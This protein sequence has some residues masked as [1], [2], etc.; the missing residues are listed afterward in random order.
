MNEMICKT[1]CEDCTR[2]TCPDKCENKLCK[3]WKAWFL[4]RWDAIH[5]YGIR[6]G[7]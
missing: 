7:K 5:A 6:Y 3:E 1:P 4:H 2:V